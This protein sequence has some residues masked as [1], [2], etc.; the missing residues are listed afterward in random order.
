MNIKRLLRDNLYILLGI[1]GFVT[2]SYYFFTTKGT[3]VV[4]HDLDYF[5]PLAHSFL[6]GRLDIFPKPGVVSD[7]SIFNGKWYP[8]WGPLPA[9]LMMPIQLVIGRYFPAAYLSIIFAGLN[10]SVAYLILTRLK[11]EYFPQALSL[12]T[13][14]VIVAFLAFG[15][16]HLFIA[17]RSGS[18]FVAQT[19]SFLPVAIGL[20]ILLKKKLT[21]KDYFFASLFIS[22]SF[23]G[24]YSLIMGMILLAFRLG[25]EWLFQKE[26][27][28]KIL[29]KGLVSAIPFLF[30]LSAFCIY[31]YLRFGNPFDFG[32]AYTVFDYYYFPTL[33]EYGP[34][35]WHYAWP[36][37]WRVFFEL[38]QLTLVNNQIALNFNH[39]GMSVFA[40]S[41]FFL[42]AFNTIRKELFHFREFNSRLQI[43][44]WV[45]VLLQA[46]LLL[47]LMTMGLN[48][49]GL[50]YATDFA[51]P[52]ASLAVFGLKGKLN[53]LAYMA[54]L[55][56]IAF[57]I[58]A[59][60][61][62]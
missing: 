39:N 57:N 30:F 1:F 51:L 12:A 29:R 40:V 24:R 52:L 45:L 17:T 60:F 13:R 34:Y 28:K 16:S 56:S 58:Y 22:L 61:G 15:T 27:F 47:P 44:L 49:V 6:S 59:L 55:I 54:I 25:D 36:N 62:L 43:Y 23:I 8:Y 32:F 26:K 38:P 19:V 53:T 11:E 50:R 33:E 14:L 7:L 42:A 46:S 5:S 37:L 10:M 35:S 21:V 31:N 18:W 20:F 3:F 48:Q 2:V 9:L 4:P 41:P